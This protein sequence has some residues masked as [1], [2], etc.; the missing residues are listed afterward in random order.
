MAA[1]RIDDDID[2]HPVSDTDTEITKETCYKKAQTVLESTDPLHFPIAFP[3]VFEE[4][5]PGFDVIIGNPPWEEELI[6]EDN[7]WRRY[8]PGLKGKSKQE[9]QKIIDGLKK[10]RPDLAE[11]YEEERDEKRKRRKILT[12]GPYPGMGTGDPDTY[13]AFS[14]RFWNL[15]HNDGYNGVV[16]PRSAFL[17]AGSEEFRRTVLNEGTI[18]DLTFLKNKQ[19]WVFEK[20]EHR[21]TIALFAFTHSTPDENQTVPL[22]G[23]Y[24]DPESYEEGIENDP[25]RFPVDQAKSWTDTAAFPL[26]PDDPRSV[27]VFDQLTSAPRLANKEAGHWRARPNTELHAT[28]DKKRDDGTTLMHFIDDPPEEYW[29]VYKGNSFELWN[30][31][32]GVRYAWADPDIIIEYLQESRENSY[33]YA[34]SRSAFAEFSEKWVNDP[35]TLPCL[36]P[37]VAFRNVSRATDTRTIICA[38]VPPETPLTNAAPYFLWPKGDERDEAYLLGILSSIPLDWYARRF[39]EANVN[40]HILN[41]LPIPRREPDDPLRQNI[42]KL[43][44]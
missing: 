26:L 11:A 34:G 44:G 43:A 31:D 6:D 22:R 8:E 19:G 38:L 27:S 14:W 40:Y 36:S 32:T 13:K 25:H 39:V 16:L 3:E 4:E 23:P 41:A 24:P 29:P 28:N 15:I 37:R 1:S 2:I 10:E 17:S 5:Q 30:P 18:T 20:A 21:Y 12:N 7:F 42:I 35:D 33:Q 9:K